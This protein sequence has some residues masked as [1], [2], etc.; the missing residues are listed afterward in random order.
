MAP[1]TP[2][3]PQSPA[4]G[5]G[6]RFNPHQPGNGTS[7]FPSVVTPQPRTPFI[8]AP[9]FFGTT[10]TSSPHF[11]S[12]VPSD[13]HTLEWGEGEIFNQPRSRADPAPPPT[14][15][16]YS[17]ELLQDQLSRQKQQEPQEK[18]ELGYD[19]HHEGTE[20][21]KRPE[22]NG[23]RLED[24]E[25]GLRLPLGR[26]KPAQNDNSTSSDYFPKSQWT[27][28]PSAKVN[29][30]L[31]NAVRAAM[32]DEGTGDVFW[33][34]TLGF[35]TGSLSAS[36]KD[37]IQEKL[38]MEYD[39]LAVY[40]SD[41]D[42]DGHYEHYCKTIL[43]PVFHYQIPDHP[44]SKAYE[45]H[46]WEYYVHVNQTVADKIIK[47]YKRGD[48]IWVHDYHLLLV[49]KMVRQKLPEAQIGFFLHS[50]F[51]SSEVFRCLSVRKQLLEGILGANLV[52][53]QIKEYAMHFLQTC[54]RLLIV[55]VTND[56][57]QLENRF[58]NVT[59]LAIGIDLQRVL[60]AQQEPLVLDSIKLL[61]E[62]YHDKHL[63]VARDKLDN[64]RGV[65]QKLLAYELFLNKYPEWREKVH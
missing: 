58:V 23:R 60:R 45:D 44:K 35:P 19:G 21:R 8:E 57:V 46:S 15:L 5:S 7:L 6:T 34:G 13:S 3:H 2:F 50:A 48:K 30:G 49:P 37:E 14:I 28:E 27:I 33:V 12:F 29:G 36:V 18:I 1:F 25:R 53:F 51:P 64:V 24:S 55:E 39:T 22:G 26:K 61:L 32:A 41:S 16:E 31:T 65:R 17:K 54:S 43:W 62:R 9:E 4:I 11:R 59:W 47:T 52:A 56:G 10:E 42:F 40:V 20:S 63:I 38:E